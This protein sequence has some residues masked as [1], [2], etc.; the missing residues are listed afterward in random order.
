[1]RRSDLPQ[2]TLDAR[3][4]GEL[5]AHPC[6]CGQKGCTLGTHIWRSTRDMAPGPKA[7]GTEPRGRSWPTDSEDDSPSEAF[8]DLNAEYQRRLTALQRAA[9]DV[10]WFIDSYRP[11]RVLPLKDQPADAS[12][13][14]CRVCYRYGLCNPRYRSDLCRDC[15]EFNLAYR[16]LDRPRELVMARHEGRSKITQQMVD[17]AVT[18]AR[19][20]RRKR[21]RRA[22]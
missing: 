13:D 9:R 5:I 1:M 8:P 10:A 14:W 4:A 21:R 3:H 6:G 7:Q 12:E 17:E 15:Y 20:D 2:V 19:R 18:R 11:D 16:D 22:A